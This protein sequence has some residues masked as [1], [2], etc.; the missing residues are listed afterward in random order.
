MV[1]ISNSF[2]TFVYFFCS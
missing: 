1:S 2:T